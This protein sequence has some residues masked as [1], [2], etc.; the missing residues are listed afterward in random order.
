MTNEQKI[1]L[2][3][4]LL[5]I[6]GIALL[7]VLIC[8]KK[9]IKRETQMIDSLEEETK[10]IYT[11]LE[12]V[13]EKYFPYFPTHAAGIRRKQGMMN[14]IDCITSLEAG[15]NKIFYLDKIIYIIN[16]KMRYQYD[17]EK[18]EEKEYIVINDNIRTIQVVLSFERPSYLIFKYEITKIE[19]NKY[20]ITL[21]KE[22]EEYDARRN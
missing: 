18:I 10:K 14:D 6:S 17:I 11:N 20:K 21:I 1:I 5:F 3:L 8:F 12:L 15:K 7:I 4:V 22:D 13:D 2:A 9:Y 19:K 16:D